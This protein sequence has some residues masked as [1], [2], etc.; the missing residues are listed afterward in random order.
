MTVIK[1]VVM[2]HIKRDAC[3]KAFI[4]HG[5]WIHKHGGDLDAYMLRYGDHGKEIFEM[6]LDKLRRLQEILIKL[7][8]ES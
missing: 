6:D 7:E 8:G 1:E 2:E 3:H 4:D 5:L